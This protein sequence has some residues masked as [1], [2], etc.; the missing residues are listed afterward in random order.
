MTKNRSLSV[1]MTASNQDIYVAPTRFDAEVVSVIVTSLNGN[2][3]TVSLD[4]YSH[5]EDEW[6]PIMDSVNVIA[7]GFIQITDA[8]L[9]ERGDKIRGLASSTDSVQVTVSVKEEF[10]QSI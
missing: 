6:Y 9:L 4:W 10:K 8:I 1:K 5:I 7:N 2:S 3:A